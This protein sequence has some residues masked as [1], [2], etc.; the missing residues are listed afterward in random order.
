[1]QRVILLLGL[2]HSLVK[3]R[4][5]SS[6][7]KMVEV[8]VMEENLLFFIDSIIYAIMMIFNFN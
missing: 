3:C 1:M 2:E 5:A 6:D 8:E 7:V 4:E